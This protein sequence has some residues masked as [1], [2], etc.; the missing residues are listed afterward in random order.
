MK[1]F[2]G[3]LIAFGK[4]RRGW[5]IGA[6]VLVVVAA[7]GLRACAPGEAAAAFQTIQVERGTLSAT[8]GAVG[9]VRAG[10]TAILAWQ[11]SGIVAA[12]NVETGDVVAA[13]DELASLSQSSL[14]PGIVLAEVD[15][16]NARRELDRLMTSDTARAQAQLALVDARKAFDQAQSHRDGL[17]Y[18]RASQAAIDNAYASYVLAR[19]GVDWAQDYYDSMASL[20]ADDPDRAQAYQQLYQA[21]RQRD[22]LE[23]NWNYLS[24]QASAQDVAEADAALA[25]A[26]ARLEDAQAEWERLQDGPDPAELAAARARLVAAQATLDSARLVAPVAGT[27]TEVRSRPGDQVSPGSVGIRIDNLSQMLVDVQV[28]EVDVNSIHVGQEVIVRFDAVLDVDYHG[29][30]RDVSQAGTSTT[31]GVNFQVTIELTGA[32]AQ[33]R[34][35]MTATVTITVEER[36]DVLLVPNRA[37]RLEEGE[38]VVYVLRNGLPE[39]VVVTL[40]V[41]SDLQSEV[42]SGDLQEG[43]E[44]LLNP[45]VDGE[46]GRIVIGGQ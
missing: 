7:V 18:R 38:H 1:K 19:Q 14:S 4:K 13:G 23:A 20:P 5:L 11:T 41:S 10:Q 40:G 26:A 35:G 16:Y 6:L 29:R 25:V 17:D 42:L 43:D 32:D 37:V 24:G 46:S 45:P 8:V 3:A 12:V 44:I 21:R 15:L 31:A 9:S 22:T 2:F 28:S 30:V 36:Q 34:P 33:V 39:R 27:V